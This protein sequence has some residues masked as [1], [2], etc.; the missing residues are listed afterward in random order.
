[1]GL[2]AGL[3]GL[4]MMGRHHARVLASLPD[5]QFV[6]SCDLATGD[7]SYFQGK[8]IY[9]LLDDLLAQK[10]D[11][12]VVAVPTVLHAEIA[13][14]L[15]DLG[16]HALIEKPIS[17]TANTARIITE[18]FNTRNLIGAVGHIERFNPA[19]REAKRRLNLLGRVFQVSTLR[20]GPF[21]GRI[22][23]VGVIKDLATHD[24]DLTSWVMDQDF[25]NVSARIAH[26]AGRTNEDMLCAVATLSKGAISNHVVNWL[27]PKKE[28]K[29]V[30]TG[31][32]GAFEID[33]LNVDLTFYSNGV[34]KSKWEDLARFRG[35]TEGDVIRFAFSKKEP[36]LIE[37]ENFRDAILGKTNEIVSLRDG[38]KALLVAE[39]IYSS[40]TTGQQVSVLDQ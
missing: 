38:L 17:D 28:R 13:V 39:A 1:V 4:G 30:V 12:A 29:I 40:A 3:I 11:Y 7:E 35:V 15:A 33:T 5:V 37:H 9:H 6:G 32:N 34:T 26:Q 16:I 2:R 22:S 20:Q 24:I 21:P 31:E 23:D 14:K 36:L 18:T 19:V 10:I 27:S 25:L 8:P